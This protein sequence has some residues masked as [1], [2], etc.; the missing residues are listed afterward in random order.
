ML[1][2]S[3][4]VQLKSKSQEFDLKSVC[5]KLRD[6]QQQH[7]DDQQLELGIKGD[8]K[9]VPFDVFVILLAHGKNMIFMDHPL[10]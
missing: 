4:Q 2:D 8:P 5:N 1:N 6:T 10:I 9:F 3:Q 7:N